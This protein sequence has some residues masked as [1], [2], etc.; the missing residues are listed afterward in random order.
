MYGQRAKKKIDVS[1]SEGREEK[2]GRK[3]RVMRE[4]L[5]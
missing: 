2:Y 5:A 4:A 3:K 1:R